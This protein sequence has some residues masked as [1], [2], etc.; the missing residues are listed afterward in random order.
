ME[1]V[2][3][4]TCRKGRFLW[5][6][7]SAQHSYLMELKIKIE[8]GYYFSESIISKIVEDLAPVMAD[9]IDNE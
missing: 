2:A 8:S 9:T 4:N 5:M 3:C 6:E 1:T 7:N